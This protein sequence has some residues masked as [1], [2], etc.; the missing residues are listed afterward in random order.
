VERRSGGARLIDVTAGGPADRAGLR[1]GDVV[2]RM[3]GQGVDDG[4]ELIVGI[5]SH[6]PGQVVSLVY[7]RDGEPQT[8]RVRLGEEQG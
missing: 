5:R 8:A 6:L 1:D 4:I 7:R 3:D 2:T